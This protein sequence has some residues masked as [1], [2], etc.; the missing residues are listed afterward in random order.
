M[1]DAVIPINYE[2]SR[3]K[4]SVTSCGVKFEG[5][6]RCEFVCFS[7]YIHT[8]FVGN[9]CVMRKT[10]CENKKFNIYD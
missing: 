10:K 2:N 9:L 1:A 7:A 8:L 5:C 3:Y 4:A 6:G